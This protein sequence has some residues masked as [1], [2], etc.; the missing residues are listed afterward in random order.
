MQLKLLITV[1]LLVVLA[2]FL[3][4]IASN[5]TNKLRAVYDYVTL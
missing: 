4:R 2:V 5:T 1:N 3:A